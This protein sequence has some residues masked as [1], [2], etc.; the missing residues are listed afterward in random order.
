MHGRTPVEARRIG[1]QRKRHVRRHHNRN[2]DKCRQNLSTCF[3]SQPHT[4]KA[5]GEQQHRQPFWEENGHTLE[6]QPQGSARHPRNGRILSRAIMLVLLLVTTTCVHTLSNGRHPM[7]DQ[8]RN[9][10][11]DRNE[12]DQARKCSKG[13]ETGQD[14]RP[15]RKQRAAAEKGE[16]NA[17]AVPDGE[18]MS[19]YTPEGNSD[20]RT[21][22]AAATG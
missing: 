3:S 20:P 21:V 12:K 9:M 11:A 19:P 13:I 7:S 2:R 16:I 1:R 17:T 14:I 6:Y 8:V 10:R 18:L 4:A 15:A 22:A 5:L